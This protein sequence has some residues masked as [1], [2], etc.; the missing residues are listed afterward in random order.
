M[1]TFIQKYLIQITDACEVAS[2]I[3]FFL[4][5]HGLSIDSF[6]K[7]QKDTCIRMAIFC[8]IIWWLIPSDEALTALTTP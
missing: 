3:A 6:T 1:T 5:L 7:G 2:F 8:F 4:Y